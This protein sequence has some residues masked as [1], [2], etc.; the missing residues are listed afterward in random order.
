M[1]IIYL[2]SALLLVGLVTEAQVAPR[3]EF[4]IQLSKNLLEVKAGTSTEFT[5]TILRSKTYTRSKGKLGFSSALPPGVSITFEPAEGLFE[6]SIATVSL[7]E[8]VK[9]GQYQIIVNAELNRTRKGSVLKL[10]VPERKANEVV[11]VNE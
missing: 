11:T 4:S 6:S 7:E 3:S 5:V 10:V 9:P 2:I 1:K 8:N